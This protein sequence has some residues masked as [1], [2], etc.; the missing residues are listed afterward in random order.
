MYPSTSRTLSTKSVIK[1][2]CSGNPGYSTTSIKVAEPVEANYV[3][4]PQASI[5]LVS[6]TVLPDS[7][8]HV[9]DYTELTTIVGRSQP[10]WLMVRNVMINDSSTFLTRSE[11]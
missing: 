1:L 9:H 3:Q 6:V 8:S 2:P 7:A 4:V 5:E 10:Q 11:A